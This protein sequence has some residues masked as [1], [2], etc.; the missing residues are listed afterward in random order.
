MTPFDKSTMKAEALRLHAENRG[1]LAVA[2]KVPLQN[3]NDL[4]LAYSPGVAEP[5]IKIAENPDDIYTYTAKGNL[6]AVV[7]DGSA[8]LGLGNIGG[9]ASLPVMEGKSLLLKAFA[10][11]DS[12][13]LVLSTQNPD[14]IVNTVIAVA[15]TFGGFLLEDISAPRC[16]EIEQRLRTALDIPVFHDDQHGTAVVVAAGLINGLKVVGKRLDQIRIV[17]EGAGASG[18]AVTNLLLELG[19][20]DLVLV[21]TKGIIHAGRGVGMNPYKE[22]IAQRTNQRGLKGHLADALRDTD[23]FVGLS[24]AGTTSKEMVRSMRR[25]PIIMALSNPEP[26]IWPEDAKEAGARI[27]CTGRSD[28]P[29]QVNNVLAFP[30]IFR[31]A[32]DVRAREINEPMKLAAARAIAAL[33]DPDRLG[34]DYIIPDSF[35]RRVAPAVAEAVARAAIEAGVAR[36]PIDPADVALRCRTLVTG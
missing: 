22:E 9:G 31:G 35:D 15:P 17:V 32:L 7:S 10:G 30:G 4:S 27:V 16:F 29:N 1:K 3:L 14:E 23:V 18:I 11:V 19:V 28:Y 24:A 12:F 34:P 8:V 6:V 13:P 33:V 26:E 36:L 2:S 20:Q 21:D 5:C 25:D